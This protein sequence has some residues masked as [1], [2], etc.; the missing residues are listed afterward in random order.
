MFLILCE[1]HF[2]LPHQAAVRSL[3][4]S[5]TLI[6]TFIA[7][8]AHAGPNGLLVAESSVDVAEIRSLSRSEA[9][10][11]DVIHQ[12]SR[13]Y[14]QLLRPSNILPQM[15]ETYNSSAIG[16]PSGKIGI[17]RPVKS[18]SDCV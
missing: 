4:V 12:I 2:P 8:S 14:G 10:V 7:E 3:E 18:I 9:I 16:S 5:A 1:F 13:A 6:L 17:G 15:I 11:D